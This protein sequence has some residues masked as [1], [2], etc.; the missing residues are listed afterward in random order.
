M[1][2]QNTS[3]KYDIKFPNDIRRPEPRKLFT[4][5]LHF[6]HK[7]ILKFTKRPAENLEEMHWKIIHQWNSFVNPED[8]VYSLGDLTFSGF[9]KTKNI[10]TQLNG[11]IHLIHGNH[12]NEQLMKR[13]ASEL[14]HVVDHGTSYHEVTEQGQKIILCHY[15][16]SCWNRER[17]GSIHLYGHCH[18][19]FENHGK[20][21]DVGIDA[22]WENYGKFR[23]LSF[24]EIMEIVKGRPI[25][26]MDHHSPKEP[27]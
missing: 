3:K 19:S 17:H 14:N 2:A 21:I 13:L 25:E 8:H 15:P 11:T 10:L 1:T 24:S 22:A 4:S 27:R 16:L 9:E 12:C 7:N 18:N 6:Y 20:S 23:P 5:D 26:P